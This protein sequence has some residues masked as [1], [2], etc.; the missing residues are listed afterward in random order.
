MSH[1][2]GGAEALVHPSLDD[3]EDDPGNPVAGA[4]KLECEDP[5]QFRY[6]SLGQSVERHPVVVAARQCS[7]GADQ[8]H[9]GGR[10]S[11]TP[12]QLDEPNH[13]D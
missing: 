1:L 9:L 4:G 2:G 11:L 13:L 12:E 7:S 6:K 5:D 8:Q 10:S 3:V